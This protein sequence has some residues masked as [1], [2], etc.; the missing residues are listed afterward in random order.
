MSAHLVAKQFWG[1]YPVWPSWGWGRL[2]APTSCQLDPRVHMGSPPAGGQSSATCWERNFCSRRT[3][4]HPKLSAHPDID[5]ECTPT[6][7]PCTRALL[8]ICSTQPYESLLTKYVTLSTSGRAASPSASISC[9]PQWRSM[10]RNKAVWGANKKEGGG[11]L[12]R[13]EWGGGNSVPPF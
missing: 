1:L 12:W 7:T 2:G 11:S 6:S 5:C 10:A 9:K 4:S 8:T 13:A 3:A